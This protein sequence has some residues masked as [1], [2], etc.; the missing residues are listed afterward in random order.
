MYNNVGTRFNILMII[1]CIVG[2]V[3][4]CQLFNLQIVNGASY[5]QQSENRLVR[6]IKVTA[7][8]GEIYD[9]YGKLLVT[10]I[11]GYN[12]N[13]YYT[14]ISKT[15]LNEVLLKLA[16][17]LEKNGDT[18]TNNFPIDFE[19]MTFNK[20]EEGAKT[21]KISNRISGDA[22]VDEVIDFYKKK[23]EIQYEDIDEVKKI[24]ALRYEIANKGYSS[25]KSVVL[26]KEISEESMLEIEERGNELSGIV[27]T[28][29]PIRKYLTQNVA[30]HIIGYIGRIGSNEYKKKKEQ[31]YSQNDMIGKSGIEATFEDFLRGKD[32][33][34]RLEMDSEGRVTD[35]EETVES[36]MGNSVVLTIDFDLQKKAEEVL[37]KYIKKIQSGGFAEKCEDA[38]SGALV[39]LD[40]KTS[41]VLALAS[42]PEYNPD[43]FTDGISASEYKK[44]FENEDM[45]MFNR[46]IQGTYSPGSTFKMVTAIAAIESGTIG[47]HEQILTKGV[48]DKGHKPACWIWK[49]YRTNHG[50][51]DA[52]KALKVSCNYYFYDVSYRMGIDTLSRYASL[53]GLGTRTGI[54]LP[55][56]VSGTLASREYIQ[57]LNERDGGKRQWMVAD[58]LSA[59]I[60]QSY[61]SFTPI[62]MA[63]YIATLANGGVKNEL[64]ILKGVVDSTG[65]DVSNK[66]VDEV[67]D[68][69]IDKPEINLGDLGFSKETINVVFEGMR[70]VTGETGGTAYSTFSSFPIEVAGKTG[71]AT[72]SSG[73][74][75]A[76]F[77]GFAPYHDPEIAVV[78]VIEHGGHG[79]YTAPA[80]KEVMEEYFG[81]GNK[82]TEEDL[83]L[84]SIDEVL[85]NN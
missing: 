80:V 71:T 67:I 20:S 1:V 31:G 74:D 72:A 56:E 51:V 69:K 73:S 76:W 24:V 75:H 57:K 16:N 46:A 52:E 17:I 21:W 58:T 44:Y 79:A 4:V 68:K 26:A 11:T 39:V 48:Y 7:P 9:R 78:C 34:M 47:I 62:Q 42:Y 82:D 81:Y 5:R 50:L 36:E 83:E 12:V 18:Y 70:S 37:E 64:T 3:F 15:K 35:K 49:G 38:K 61:N 19:T 22:S 10:S 41:E 32:G 77:V 13:L 84:K 40:T 85:I 25:F 63:Y 33:K 66:E 43:E 2:V 65:K 59:G 8:R 55:G 6:E 23:Y 27:V 29:Y 54:E 30:S 60:G 14:K 45:P 28:T 53:F